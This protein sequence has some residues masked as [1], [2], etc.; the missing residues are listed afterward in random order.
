MSLQQARESLDQTADAAPARGAS[1]LA[2]MLL[3][4]VVAL[5]VAGLVVAFTGGETWN[6]KLAVAPLELALAVV[7][8]LV[9]A[10]TGHRLG[11]LFLAAS[12]TGAAA[13]F[14]GAY[15]GR[16]PAAELPGAAWLGWLFPVAVG[17]SNPFLFLIPLLFPNGRTP[18]PRWRVVA[19]V[20]IAEGLV[21]GICAALSNVDFSY[22]FP[23]LLDPVT[24][25]APLSA[26]YNLAE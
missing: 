22:N 23:R 20:A 7:G 10:R 9:A 3:G 14:L 4:L 5:L 18:S 8:A 12:A 21:E 19:W 25:V 11:W 6:S 1:R 17:F 13:I 2:W 16:V 24:L 15:A 26:P